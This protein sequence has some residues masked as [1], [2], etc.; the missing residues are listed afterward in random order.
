MDAASH[1]KRKYQVSISIIICI[2]KNIGPNDD[3]T[4]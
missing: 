3:R 1:V 4:I 2:L